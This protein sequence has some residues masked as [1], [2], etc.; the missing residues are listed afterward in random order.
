MRTSGVA[1]TA[2]PK[3]FNTSAANDDTGTRVQKRKDKKIYSW[4]ELKELPEP[5]WLLDR[6]LPK[7]G[8]VELYGPP[9]VGKTFL[10]LHWGLQL[11]SQGQPVLY[12]AGEGVSGLKTRIQAWLTHA[13]PKHELAGLMIHKGPVE[14]ASETVPQ[15]FRD[16]EHV[17]SLVVVDTLAR[18][19]GTAD[20]NSAKDMNGFV[21]GCDRLRGLWQG[22]TVLV[23]H[24]TGK[25]RSKGGRGSTAL[26]GAVDAS[27]EMDPAK[28]GSFTLRFKKMKD[29]AKGDAQPMRLVAAN[30]SCV[31]E[32]VTG[33]FKSKLS[34]TAAKALQ[35]IADNQWT[36][37]EWRQKFSEAGISKGTPDSQRKSFGRAID[38][39]K[40]AGSIE[41]VDGTHWRASTNLGLRAEDPPKGD[42][43]V[44]PVVP[45]DNVQICPDKVPTP[46]IG[47]IPTPA[48]DIGETAQQAA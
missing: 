21:S 7:D 36:T 45:N 13:D 14:I 18:S 32:P 24:H 9:N 28:D 44:C 4:A 39:L 37:E 12:I 41:L 20:E 23:L 42:V 35:L 46:A 22:C 29:W 1:A 10:A 8:L 31:V 11:V 48:N 17:P 38:Q 40:D 26:H 43:H 16:L 15:D 5:E 6:I 19:F 3:S 34:A 47:S 2:G 27:L 33:K 25:D 30:G